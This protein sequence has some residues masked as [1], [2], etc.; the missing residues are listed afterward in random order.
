MLGS[1]IMMDVNKDFTGRS[2][3][4]ILGRLTVRVLEPAPRSTVSPRGRTWGRASQPALFPPTAPSP[5]S[6]RS[7]VSV[8]AC[9]CYRLAVGFQLLVNDMCQ[10]TVTVTGAGSPGTRTSPGRQSLII[11]LFQF[12]DSVSCPTAFQTFFVLCVCLSFCSVLWFVTM[13]TR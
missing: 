4:S 1:Q 6:T 8:K 2:R 7:V 13:K 10:Q 9:A 11:C 12:F 5:T 3:L